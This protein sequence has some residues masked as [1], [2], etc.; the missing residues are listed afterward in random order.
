MLG[1]II[2]LVAEEI[3]A[4]EDAVDAVE[5]LIYEKDVTET[6]DTDSGTKQEIDQ[7]ENDVEGI[8]QTSSRM[9]SNPGKTYVIYY[10]PELIKIA[11]DKTVSVSLFHFQHT[12]IPLA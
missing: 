12:A 1:I 8:L 5:Q 3:E 10:P 2:L 4:E 6:I 11:F 9:V 7:D